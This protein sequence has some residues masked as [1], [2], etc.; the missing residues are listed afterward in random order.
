MI[1]SSSLGY[2]CRVGQSVSGIISAYLGLPLPPLSSDVDPCSCGGH[3]CGLASSTAH[4]KFLV[5]DTAGEDAGSNDDAQ[6]WSVCAHIWMF[7][8]VS[9]PL[10]DY[11]CVCCFRD[12]GGGLSGE[13]AAQALAD[14]RTMQL[15]IAECPHSGNH[16]E[17]A[18][19]RLPVSA[20]CQASGANKLPDP[21]SMRVKTTEGKLPAC[22]Q[23]C[24]DSCRANAA[25]ARSPVRVIDKVTEKRRID[26]LEHGVVDLQAKRVSATVDQR[27]EIET[28]PMR[29]AP[30]IRIPTPARAS[31]R[32]L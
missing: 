28:K 5:G 4:A 17:Q 1:E 26:W 6:A 20:E 12:R 22:T 14:T 16:S 24:A 2:H 31:A 29:R 19:N 8:G 3:L 21:D 11:L 25:V 7:F 18:H 9:R 32:T 13:S 23:D 15:C 30:L 10:G 27:P